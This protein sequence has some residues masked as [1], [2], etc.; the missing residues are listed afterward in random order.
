[1]DTE[2]LREVLK[3]VDIVIHLAAKKSVSESINN[4]E[5]YF[6]QNSMGTLNLLCAM[7][8]ASVEK[9]I[10]SSTAAVYKPE[11]SKFASEESPI[12]PISPYGRS[13]SFGEDL[14]LSFTNNYGLRAIILRYFNVVAFES[15]YREPAFKNTGLFPSLQRAYKERLP[16]EIFGKT[17]STPDG[18]AIRDFVHV[19][20]LSLA[21]LLALE[22]LDAIPDSDIYNV[23]TNSGYSIQ[24]VVNAFQDRV[25]NQIEVRIAATREGDI[26]ISIADSSKIRA[27]LD[28]A[29]RYD[30]AEIVKCYV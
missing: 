17:F 8:R 24:E 3:G 28:W 5:L 16:F 7:R 4:P 11:C 10:F 12:S 14:V 23:G 13:K 21:H 30:L 15:Y 26:P 19:A 1:M 27:E 18:T 9:F 25:N 20:D 6:E 2:I 22:K 29:P